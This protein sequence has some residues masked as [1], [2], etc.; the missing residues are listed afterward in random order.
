[1]SGSASD[2]P[3]KGLLR[4]RCRRGMRELDAA[5][6][7]YLDHHY[8]TAPVPEQWAFCDFLD[9]PDPELIRLVASYTDEM[10]AATG[11]GINQIKQREIQPE[12]EA[13][14]HTSGFTS[15]QGSDT[16]EQRQQDH[17]R[18]FQ[19]IIEKIRSTLIAG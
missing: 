14:S 1:M 12:M 6:I 5:L 9:I 16:S 3:T 4:W 15:Q 17:S 2:L 13:G 7:A 10:N 18:R 8:D 11:Y 19:P